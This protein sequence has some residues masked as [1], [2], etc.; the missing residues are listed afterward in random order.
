MTE[1]N[2]K[3]YQAK[4]FENLLGMAGFS[5][6]MLTNHFTLYQ[7]YVANTEKL[8]AILQEMTV[9]GK[10]ATPEFAELKRRFGWEYN[11]M[12]LHEYYF[13]NMSKDTT[14]PDQYADFG[15]KIGADFGRFEAW[16]KEFK[17]IG[18]MRGIGWVVLYYDHTTGRFFNCWINEHDGGHLANATPI[19]I[20]DV[21]E[22][23]YLTD[24][25]IKRADYIESFF[26]V[27]DWTVVDERWNEAQQK[28]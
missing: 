2:K 17:A 23:A 8:I 20:M 14:N 18:A 15:Q 1:V 16:V 4:N 19:L 27:I 12:K 25:S 5:D 7:G 28:K 6:T 22:H 26:Q 9:N 11:G 21:F 13:E 24:Y 10:T 3:P